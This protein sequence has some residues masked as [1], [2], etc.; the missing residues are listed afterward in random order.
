MPSETARL[1]AACIS[2]NSPRASEPSARPRM[3]PD[4]AGTAMDVTIT[5]SASTRINSINVKA[6][7]FQSICV[8]S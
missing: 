5:S 4:I 1:C 6:R 3:N 7:R 8:A 2:A